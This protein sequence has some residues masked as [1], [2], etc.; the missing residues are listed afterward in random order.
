MC[1]STYF[2][3][4]IIRSTHDIYYYDFLLFACLTDCVKNLNTSDSPT[5][6]LEVESY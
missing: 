2:M 4:I 6:R 5:A 1:G 3:K